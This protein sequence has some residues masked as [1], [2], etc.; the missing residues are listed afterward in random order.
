M[1]CA[2]PAPAPIPAPEAPMACHKPE[3]VVQAPSVPANHP[4]CCMKAVAPADQADH[5]VRSASS[6]KCEIQSSSGLPKAAFKAVVLP[7]LDQ[8][9]DAV[10]PS[11]VFVAAVPV[12]VSE[13]GIFGVDSGPPSSATFLP[14]LGRAPPVAR[15]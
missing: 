11:P 5:E 4:N 1:L 15:A 9:F 14:D 13:P 2:M 12:S 8:S 10:E 7:G 3:S 6:C